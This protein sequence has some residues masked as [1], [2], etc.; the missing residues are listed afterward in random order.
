MKSTVWNYI[1][2]QRFVLIF[3]AS[4]P[5]LVVGSFCASV[6]YS[7]CLIDR[8]VPMYVALASPFYADFISLRLSFPVSLHTH[9]DPRESE[10]VSVGVKLSSTLSTV[11]TVV[12]TRDWCWRKSLFR[13]L[14]A[15]L[16]LSSCVIQWRTEESFKLM[17][18]YIQV[19]FLVNNFSLLNT[20]LL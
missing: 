14:K 17:L 4:L 9:Y 8:T 16:F 3:K 13:L 12:S 19:R 5:R 2:V 15:A 7:L 1:Q 18:M 11:A 10:V 20:R 6:P